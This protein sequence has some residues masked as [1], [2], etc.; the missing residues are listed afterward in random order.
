M[1]MRPQVPGNDDGSVVQAQREWDACKERLDAESKAM[2]WADST[3]SGNQ[4]ELQLDAAPG[5]KTSRTPIEV[6][7]VDMLNAVEKHGGV[8]KVCRL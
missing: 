3:K 8:T 1:E 7:D 2:S 6:S 4:R 5:W